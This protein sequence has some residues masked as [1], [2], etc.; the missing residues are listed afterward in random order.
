MRGHGII[1]VCNIDLFLGYETQFLTSRAENSIWGC[2]Q[3][4][5]I[6]DQGFLSLKFNEILSIL[7]Q[8]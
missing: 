6:G 7:K 5:K 2:D 4:H 8:F 1:K 3:R